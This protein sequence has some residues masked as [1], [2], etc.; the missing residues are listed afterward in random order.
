LKQTGILM[1]HVDHVD[2]MDYLP[3]KKS[4]VHLVYWVYL[5]HCKAFFSLCTC[6]INFDGVS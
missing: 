1:D 4:V 6:R 5:V 2:L 3:A